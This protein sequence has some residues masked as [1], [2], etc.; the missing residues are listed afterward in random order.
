VCLFDHYGREVDI[1][2]IRSSILSTG[3]TA[4]L[5]IMFSVNN[6][7]GDG[8]FPHA[9]Q[10]IQDHENYE[11]SML[12]VLLKEGQKQTSPELYINSVTDLL[13]HAVNENKPDLAKLLIQAGANLEK[14]TLSNFSRTPLYHAAY[15]GYVE[16]TAAL[17]EANAD[18][19]TREEKEDNGWEVIHAA[20]D[21]ANIL[22]MLLKGNVDIN[23]RT[24]SSSTALMLAVRNQY[25][26]SVKELPKHEP[27]LNCTYKNGS[28]LSYCVRNGSNKI[29]Y[30]LLDT[31]MDPC[32]EHVISIN[33]TQLHICVKNNNSELLRRLLLYNFP[34][35]EEDGHGRTP[36]NCLT[37]NTDVETVRLLL[38]RGASMNVKDNWGDTPLL[39]AVRCNNIR[40][41]EFLLSRGASV[42]IRNRRGYTPLY[43][44]CRKS[45]LTMVKILIDSSDTSRGEVQDETL[46]QSVCL[47]QGS[48]EQKSAVLAYLIEK[49]KVYPRQT[50]QKWGNNLSV[51]CLAMDRKTYWAGM[52]YTLLWLVDILALSNISS[53]SN[54]PWSTSRTV[55]VGRQYFGP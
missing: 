55:M 13:A 3:T 49:V 28:L 46:F 47:G 24:A 37:G 52:L 32:H 31:S 29:A 54:R 18:P 35:E 45:S 14:K 48:L 16:I 9:M 42:N 22:R 53:K 30:M 7:L 27:D 34:L 26:E 39:T 43:F 38:N 10:I 6:D 21:N 4:M 25:E 40:I 50:S 2:V 17:I 20:Y 19:H 23:V 15:R 11:P 36:L 44:A 5:Q 33:K 8:I 1:P 51:A 12:E 41:A